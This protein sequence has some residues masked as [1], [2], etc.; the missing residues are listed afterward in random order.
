MIIPKQA[1]WALGLTALAFAS[2]A[3]QA[4]PTISGVSNGASFQ[5]TFSPGSLV[6]IF[7]KN[8]IVSGQTTTATI[9][10]LP[11]FVLP[12]ATPTQ[13]DLQLPVTAPVGPGVLT[14]AVGT[15]SVSANIT[16]AAYA[17]AFFQANSS[18]LGSFVDA[19]KATPIT[20]A[21]P[22]TPGEILT[23]YAVGLGITNPAVPTGGSPASGTTAP[24]VAPVTMTLG[25]EAVTVDFAG[26][27]Q[28]GIYQINLTVPK[29]ASACATS[30]VLTV[31]T[32]ANSPGTSAPAVTLPVAN[33]LPTVCA[34]EN[35]A[36]GAV[37]DATHAAAANSFISVYVAGMTGPD[38][39]SSLFP[40]TS[41]QGIEVDFNDVPMPLYA[42]LPSVNL[43]NTMLP[44][45]A[46]SSG[47][48]TLTVKTANGVSQDYTVELAPADMGVF[49]MP[50]PNDAARM[51]AVA[52][53]TGTYWFA[54]PASLA[55]SYDL[56]T[57]CTGLP[58]ATPC[59][60]PAHPGDTI[61][62]YYT[63]GGLATPG[64]NPSAQP[65]ATGSV[66][67][68]NGSVIYDTILTPAVTIGGYTVPNI[69]FSGIAPGTSSEY[70]LNVTI[71]MGVSAGNDVPVVISMGGSTDTVTI[72]VQNP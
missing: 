22:A 2:C 10:T 43:I 38:S 69:L 51:Q 39:T 62:I 50:D 67:P 12:G 9:G 71:P 34:V 61:V 55:P 26:L 5:P 52:L 58:V 4:Q 56:P 15:A 25:T 19:L 28:P 46:G 30:L 60:Q 13:I 31:G 6:A 47:S 33:P 1:R 7:G 70:Q 17:P 18:G 45:N 44:S 49:R 63:G 40:A 23:G 11:C 27:T 59:G 65:V 64:A 35:S 24:T 3:A 14:V 54:M 37:R 48:G 20:A 29:D 36:T 72:A 16:L 66:A 41:Y 8:L 57:P 21:N 53:V 42:V 68:V 32:T